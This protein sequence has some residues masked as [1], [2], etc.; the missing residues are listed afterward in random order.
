ML[1][2]LL[3]IA[4]ATTSNSCFGDIFALGDLQGGDFDS[5]GRALSA[6]GNVVVGQSVSA[7]GPEAFRWTE[8]EG[9]QGLGTLGLSVPFFSSAHATSGDGSVVVGQSGV[10]SA[11]NAFRW[12]QESGMVALGHLPGGQSKTTATGVSRD[13]STVVGRSESGNGNE[14]YIW[15]EQTGMVGLGDLAGGVFSSFGFNISGDGSTVVGVGNGANGNEAIQWSESG[16]MVGLGDLEGGRFDSF[17]TAANFDG[18][19]IVG[20]G[21]NEQGGNAV[22]WTNGVIASLGQLETSASTDAIGVSDDGSVV[23]GYSSVAAGFEGF[24]WT[25]QTGMESLF[26]RLEREGNDLS[27]WQRLSIVYG[28]SA[29]GRIVAGEGINADGNTEAFLATLATPIPEPFAYP[30]LLVL[31][32]GVLGRKRRERQL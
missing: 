2:I 5:R 6:D 30:V 20:R 7:D 11:G 18:S 25:E 16:G 4:L 28:V 14:G 29:D 19:I 27:H 3:L 9:I 1:R 31:S 15:T 32:Y 24:V 26:D 23:V 8:Q 22:M 17:A 12:T 13:G 10:I 21:V